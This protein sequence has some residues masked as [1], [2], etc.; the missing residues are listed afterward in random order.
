MIYRTP[1]PRGQLRRELDELNEM[2]AQLELRAGEPSRWMGSLRRQVRTASIV[3]STSIEGFSV[4]PEEAA[5]LVDRQAVG[6]ED[7]ESR[8]AVASYAHAMDHVGSMALDPGF[9]WLDRVILDLHFDACWFQRD[10]SPGLWRTGPIGVTGADGSL[11]FRGPDGDEIPALIGEIVAWL[12]K[13]GPGV[14]VVVRAAMAHLNVISVHPF[15]DGNGRVSRIV[16]SLVLALDGASA[17]ELIS[18]EEYLGA[19]T[20][21]YY[22]ALREAQGGSFQPDRDAMPW[23]EF[24]VEAHIAQARQRLGQI[25]RAAARWGNLEGLVEERRWP[26]RLTIAL[27]QGLMGR[28]DR[29]RYAAEAGVSPATASADIRRL[30]D[31]GLLE[32]RGQ[33]RNTAYASTRRLWE[34]GG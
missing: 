4:D 10:K 16:Q 12:A 26:E 7:S 34:V 5:E 29:A 9:R 17:P 23:V 18:I 2:R 33:G 21:D 11:E 24:C 14:D 22:A 1:Q 32:Q 30:L 15:R 3:G 31:A 20:D 8:L 27:E 28:T 13:G 25:E 6:A 19:H